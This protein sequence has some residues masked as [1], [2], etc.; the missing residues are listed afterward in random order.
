MG[1]RI[2]FEANFFILIIHKPSLG[3]CEVPEKFWAGSVQPFW[4]L[5]DT[6]KQTNKQTKECSLSQKMISRKKKAKMIKNH[7]LL[8][9][10]LIFLQVSDP[11]FPALCAAPKWLL[12]LGFSLGYGA[13]FTKVDQI[14]SEIRELGA[15]FYPV[16]D[17]E[18]S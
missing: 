17:L 12:S 16:L 8:L 14:L 6:N 7:E 4:R 10:K 13:M 3:T 5:L 2:L 1:N 11:M 15:T 9:I 18:G